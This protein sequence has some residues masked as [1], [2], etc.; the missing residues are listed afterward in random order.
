MSPRT[1]I[2]FDGETLPA[3][4][5]SDTLP[6]GGGGNPPAKTM[7]QDQ[8]NTILA[9]EK[10]KHQ[11]KQKE[12][13]Q[14]LEQLQ[15]S[16][17]L[18]EEERTALNTQVEEL[19]LQTTTS[20]ERAR[21]ALERQKKEYDG[22]LTTATTERDEWR[23]RYTETA[24]GHEIT[25]A[26]VTNEAFAPSQIAAIL[27][28]NTRLTEELDETGKPTGRLIPKVKFDALDKDGKAITLDL[29]VTEAVKRMKETPDVYGNLFKSNAQGGLGTQA[30]A[31]QGKGGKLDVKNMPP[32]TYRKIRKENPA[33]LGL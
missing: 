13:L 31:G 11:A 24:I 1:L 26:A 12:M 25:N 7:T 8:V 19:R 4:S 6:A 30:P 21:T 5:G 27:R 16:T 33:S 17:R 3:G 28:P 32:G 14:Q 22:K 18:S 29:T 10:R 23:G 9:E 15:T 20:E 2:C